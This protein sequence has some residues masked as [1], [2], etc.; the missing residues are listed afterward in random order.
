MERIIRWFVNNSVAANM[1]MLFIM[2]AGIMTLPRMKME[3]FPDINLD[4]VSINVVYPGA[5]PESVEEAICLKIEEKLSGLKGVKR[6]S[7]TASENIGST[8]VEVL[9]GE[10]INEIKDNIQTKIDAIDSFPN[11]AEKPIVQTISLSSE[12]VTVAVY[13][14][15]DEESLNYYA[16]EIKNEID[17]LDEVSLTSIS[18]KKS[19][20][21]SIEISRNNLQKYQLTMEQVSN[22]IRLNSMDM[23]GGGIDTDIGEILIRSK[24]Q[25]YNE[26]EFAK[27]PII[28]R[29]DGSNLLLGDIATIKDGF[30][31]VEVYT[32]FNNKPAMYI[33][34]FRI[35]DQNSLIISAAIKEYVKNKSLELPVGV[36]ATLWNNEAELLQA[37]IDLLTK[38]A[39]LG[40]ALVIVV[41]ALFLKTNLAGWVSLGIPISF[42]GGFMLMPIVD[43][44]INMLSLFTFILVLGIVVDDAIVVGENIYLWKERGLEA[45]EAAIKGAHQ[46]S[47]PVIFAV[48]TTMVTFSPM[49]SV[50]GNVGQ[51]WRI[52]PLITIV[53]LIFSLVESLTILPAHLGHIK[54]NKIKKNNFLTPFI[55]KWESLQN[56]LRNGIEVFVEQKYRPFLN[57]SIHNRLVTAA[58]SL[59]LLLL[60]IGIIAGGWM[61]FVFFPAVESDLLI[62]NIVYPN[63]SPVEL[64][65]SGLTILE[66]SL[67]EL[68]KEYKETYPDHD[69]FRNIS[70][71]AGGQPVRNATQQGP[72]ALSSGESGSHLAELAIELS[73]GE[74]RPITA[75]RIA[76]RFREI[77]PPIIGAKEVNFSSELFSAGE[78]VNV[79]LSSNDLEEL[80]GASAYLKEK[81]ASYTGVIDIKDSFSIGKEEIQLTLLPS[82]KNYGI[83]MANLAMQVRQA[84]YGLEVQS[85]SRGK[86]EVKVFI[87]YPS[88]ERKTVK[89][90]ENL[91]VRTPQQLE[92][93]IRQIANLE[94]T[95]GYSNIS[96]IDRKRAINVTADVDISKTTSNE[97][98]ASVT[99]FDLPS[100]Q[101]FFPRV[102][103]SLEGEQ[104]EQT[105]SLGSI[106]RNFFFAMIVVYTL[107]AI[108]FRSYLQPFVIMSA[109]PFGLTGALLGH[110]IMGQNLTVLSLIGIV[111]LAG[112]VVNDSLVLVDFINRYREDGHSTIEA[113]LEA[114]PRRFRPILLTSLTTF[115]GLFPLLLEKSFQAQWLIPMA[116]SLAFG[117]LFATVIT[118]IMV[119]S[120]YLIIEDI[121]VWSKKSGV[122]NS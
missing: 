76:K 34:V 55:S 93:P 84:F 20:E 87:R 94:F 13:G 71:T 117:V 14:D 116:T 70:A 21:I 37:R 2:V 67:K 119:P 73:P 99:Q 8:L 122:V 32:K 82:A 88:T 31:D 95:Q 86:D 51:I 28:S 15:I 101:S 90:L 24:G 43:V 107:L 77:T 30:A 120:F 121:R 29:I 97:V 7:S 104:Q 69:I 17:A 54:D 41:L 91:L 3:V 89:S 50:S 74:I 4:I 36:N 68:E 6:I 108:P 58:S 52:I 75:T 78:A 40:L 9:P 98:V 12:V 10:D 102:N 1:L 96:R 106:F 53:V 63:G 109:I 56:Y 42:L 49:L 113:V 26:D 23:P 47:T 11:D 81:L 62:A 5:S 60:T 61:K 111:A 19:R 118:L 79:Q 35:G 85:L 39:L 57:W 59:A 25:A 80:K 112:V 44:S 22:I 115:F 92:I 46:V 65:Q 72:G 27:I 105:E 114:G 103:Y 48:L 64:S 38:N 110:I 33:S 83:T 16:D 100:L 66:E 45:K 18:G